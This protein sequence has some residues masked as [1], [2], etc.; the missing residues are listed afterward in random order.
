MIH[1]AGLDDDGLRALGDRRAG[2]IHSGPSRPTFFCLLG[3]EEKSKGLE[4]S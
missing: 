1:M 2:G 3:M 4:N